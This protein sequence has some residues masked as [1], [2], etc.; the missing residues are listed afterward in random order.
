MKSKHLKLDL[1]A[2][3]IFGK[4]QAKNHPENI[5]LSL[6]IQYSH[7]TPQSMGEMWQFW[8]CKNI[9]DK[10]PEYITIADWNPLEWVGYGL[11]EAKAKE[12]LEVQNA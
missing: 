5:M 1:Y 9:P 4:D 7:S 3:H 8:N 12:I 11:S 2:L 6:G 10:L